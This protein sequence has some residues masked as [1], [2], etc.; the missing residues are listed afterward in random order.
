MLSMI[1]SVYTNVLLKKVLSS[2]TVY[3]IHIRIELPILM[4]KRNI[5][6]VYNVT[7]QMTNI[8]IIIYSLTIQRHT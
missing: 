8:R 2:N 3:V 5:D 7:L 6:S 4:I 1:C